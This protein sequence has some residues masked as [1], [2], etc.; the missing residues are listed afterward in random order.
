M[1]NWITDHNLSIEFADENIQILYFKWP[2]ACTLDMS[3][4]YSL[5]H[6]TRSYML[7]PAKIYVKE[8]HE[9]P[10]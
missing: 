5:S 1:L 10:V 7:E 2:V 4:P 6:Q 8:F 3:K 9:R